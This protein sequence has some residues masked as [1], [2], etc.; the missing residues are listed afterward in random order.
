VTAF[1]AKC[2]H[3]DAGA[4]GG[5]RAHLLVMCVCTCTAIQR[6][7]DTMRH[8]ARHRCHSLVVLVIGRQAALAGG[9][10]RELH[11]GR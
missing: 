9:I 1:D 2:R 4:R 5:E 7:R 3:D 10:P 6:A 8:D 11:R